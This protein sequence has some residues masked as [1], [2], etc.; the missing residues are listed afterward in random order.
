MYKN[1]HSHIYIYIYIL[2]R[3][4]PQAQSLQLWPPT[5]AS[6][7]QYIYIYIYILEA[8]VHVH[9]GRQVQLFS[10]VLALCTLQLVKL[11]LSTTLQRQQHLKGFV[12]HGAHLGKIQEPKNKMKPPEEEEEEEV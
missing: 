1:M 11:Q 12:R 8:H 7:H 2:C 6:S 9:E 4:P 3:R 10:P 5:D